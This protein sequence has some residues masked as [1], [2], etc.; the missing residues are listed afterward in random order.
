M[1]SDRPAWV[2]APHYSLPLDASGH[3]VGWYWWT[4]EER[5]EYL[6]SCAWDAPNG[7]EPPRVRADA[8]PVTD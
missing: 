2:P 4:S 8:P 6:Q 5:Y 1:S 7:Y 3:P